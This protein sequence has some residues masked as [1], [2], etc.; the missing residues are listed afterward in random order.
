MSSESPRYPPIPRPR[1]DG[2]TTEKQKIFIRTFAMTRN[3]SRSAAAAGMSRESAYRLRRRAEGAAL[4]QSWDWILSLSPLPPQA[5]Q[6]PS[7]GHGEGHARRIADLHFAGALSGK[8]HKSHGSHNIATHRQA[9][10]PKSR[11]ELQAIVD[12]SCAG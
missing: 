7:R 3:V 9:S 2:W 12:R 8:G 6:V 10:P 4:A 1:H 5:P 11:A